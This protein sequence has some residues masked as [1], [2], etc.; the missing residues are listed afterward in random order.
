MEE[1]RGRIVIR[2]YRAVFDLERR[3]Y[4]VDR[5]RLNPAGVPVLALVYAAGLVV[6]VLAA[7]AAPLAGPLVA[8]LPWQ[9]RYVAVPCGLAA[10]AVMLRVDGRPAHVA[11]ASLVRF[12]AG[13]RHLCGFARCPAPGACWTPRPLGLIAD[14]SGPRPGRVRFRGP[15]AVLVRAAHELSGRRRRVALTLA[16]TDGAPAPGR[17]VVVARGATLEVRA[18]R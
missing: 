9:L 14:G 2:S 10:L 16:A 6:A 8:V 4:R 1:G 15:G 7:Q 11:L 12:A 18:P 3:I 13:P 17:A 5:W